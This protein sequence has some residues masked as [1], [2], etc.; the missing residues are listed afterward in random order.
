MATRE[1]KA[2]SKVVMDAVRALNDALIGAGREGLHVE[3]THSSM[4]GNFNGGYIVTTI[5][6][7][8][9]VLP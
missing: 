3:L 9:T 7:R 8:E 1:Q 6:A 5:E 2:A 4:I